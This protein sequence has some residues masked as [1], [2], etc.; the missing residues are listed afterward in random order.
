[1]TSPILIVPGIG[2]SGPGHWQ[3][4]WQ[5]QDVALIRAPLA[6]W[7]H[8]VCADW[9]RTIELTVRAMGPS[10]V[11]VA[12][13]LGCLAVAHWAAGSDTRIG[14]AML[15]CVPDPDGPNFPL[16]ASGFAP[17]PRS[18]FDFPS[19]IV[20]SEDDPYASD[21]HTREHARAWGSKLV[22]VGRKG[23]INASSGVGNWPEGQAL[24]RELVS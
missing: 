1:M 23:H 19:L 4:L 9:V 13:S 17:L 10:V 3:S 15:V 2:N 20:A 12:H 21:S 6:E 5:Q 14:G 24:L 11:I 22:S 16:E 7:D 18:A 8:P